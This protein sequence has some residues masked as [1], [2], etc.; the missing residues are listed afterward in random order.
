MST[1]TALVVPTFALALS[2]SK[3]LFVPISLTATARPGSFG[4]EDTMGNSVEVN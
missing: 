2:E 3:M 4:P 1:V